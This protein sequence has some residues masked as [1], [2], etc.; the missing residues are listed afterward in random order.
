MYP[1]AC[2]GPDRV[3]S[4]ADQLTALSSLNSDGR[5][6]TGEPGLRHSTQASA[7]PYLVASQDRLDRTLTIFGLDER[8]GC[9]ALLVQ[10]HDGFGADGLT[11]S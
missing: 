9:D 2:R 10:R 11:A 6:D 1:P 3:V 8:S 5:L 4:R 7:G